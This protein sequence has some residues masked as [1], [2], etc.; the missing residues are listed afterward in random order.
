[1]GAR[2]WWAVCWWSLLFGLM[3]PL[4]LRLGGVDQVRRRAHSA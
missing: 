4:L 3:M 2:S 1:V